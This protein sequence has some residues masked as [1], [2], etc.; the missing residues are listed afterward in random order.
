MRC[1]TT[2][3]WC[4]TWSTEMLWLHACTRSYIDLVKKIQKNFTSKRKFSS[5]KNFMKIISPRN[6][7]WNKTL[8]LVDNLSILAL[9]C[10]KDCWKYLLFRYITYL[11]MF[12]KKF[13]HKNVNILKMLIFTFGPRLCHTKSCSDN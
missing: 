12:W 4:V 8:L 3:H 7:F 11:R 5:E 10:I 1:I 2:S 13:F 9:C 6:F